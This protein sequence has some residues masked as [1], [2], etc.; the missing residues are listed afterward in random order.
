MTAIQQAGLFLVQFI[1]SL[2]AFLLVLRIWLRAVHADYY[3]PMV[4]SVAKLTTP[5]VKRFTFI[6]DIKSIECASVVLLFFITLIKLVLVSLIAGQVPHFPGLIL[7]TLGTLLEV[8]LD[9]VFYMM[10]FMALLSWMPH[11][12]PTLFALLNQLTQPILQPVRR[13]LPLIAGMDFSAIAVLAV[14]Q[15]LE[16]LLA[17]PWIRIGLNTALH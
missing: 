11:V 13:V 3:H 15:I 10:M 7:W 12:Q 5:L 6:A 17:H 9:T 4:M 1:F 16:I 2:Y 8:G 14:A